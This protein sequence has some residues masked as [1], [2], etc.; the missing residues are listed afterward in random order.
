MNP[1]EKI[2]DLQPEAG[3][4]MYGWAKDLFPICRSITGEGV[5][6]T[7]HYISDNITP[8][9][10]HSVSSGVK[11]FDWV[12]PDEWSINDA[13]IED[14]KGNRILEFSDNNLHVVSYSD[15]INKVVGRE[16]MFNHLH[17]LPDQID[18]IPYVTSYYENTWGFCCSH[19][20]K[21]TMKD[22]VYRVYID[23]SKKAGVLN[24]AEVIIPGS[25]SDKEIFLS[26]YICHPS[27]ANNEL[28]GPMVMAMLI[29]LLRENPP[30]KYTIR[31]VFIPETIGSITYIS[32]NFNS[33][34]KNIVAGFNITCVG[35]DRCYSFLPS[36]NGSTISDKVSKHVL[37]HIDRNYFSYSWR[38]RGS[39]ERQYCS[40][41]VDLPIASIMRSKYNEYPEYHTSLDN[42][43]VISKNGLL[44]GLRAIAL[45]VVAVDVNY[46]PC[47]VSLCEPMLGKHKLVSN[48]SIKGAG[49]S[50][51]HFGRDIRGFISISDGKHD[52]LDIEDFLSIP[53]WKAYE[54]SQVLLKNNLI[55]SGFSKRML[56]SDD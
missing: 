25:R 48:T 8:L 35:D 16:E 27:L 26:T 50:G 6:E 32:K 18:A 52:L 23:S 4:E 37:T 5:R 19:N 38:D 49:A 53:I 21:N 28:S 39:D 11:V 43:D 12:V 17:T 10:M 44:G 2:I 1:F 51:M 47:T 24:Y 34:K 7:L 31:A 56:G 29:K 55:T 20:L 14:M 36:R 3:D 13:W 42:L 40:P 54:I 22:D 15:P 30:L 45:A 33:M 46:H 9:T 41:G